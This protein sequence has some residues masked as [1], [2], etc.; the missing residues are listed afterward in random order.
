L[1]EQLEEAGR[2][3][4]KEIPDPM[5]QDT[6]Y[7]VDAILDSRDCLWFLEM[8][9]NPQVHPDVYLPMLR[10]LFS[11]VPAPAKA[12]D[13]PSDAAPP[14]IPQMQWA[15]NRDSIFQQVKGAV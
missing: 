1:Q 6:V 12:I 3:L 11:R 5:R 8:N 10:N 9:S 13:P 7:T 2:I 4:W 14:A 15:P